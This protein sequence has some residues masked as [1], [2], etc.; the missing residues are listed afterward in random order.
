MPIRASY[1]TSALLLKILTGRTNKGRGRV[2]K[3]ILLLRVLYCIYHKV[4]CVGYPMLPREV[5]PI[6]PLIAPLILGH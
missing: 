6:A 3:L 1:S 2:Q 4:H 5:V